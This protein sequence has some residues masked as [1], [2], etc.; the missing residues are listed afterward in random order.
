VLFPCLHGR[1]ERYHV[2]FNEH[3]Q[4][5]SRY[6]LCSFA[7]APTSRQKKQQL[8]IQINQCSN[9]NG[10]D[11]EREGPDISLVFIFILFLKNKK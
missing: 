1:A 6:R 5:V 4:C 9:L 7:Q 3:R 8:N 2:K 11:G 10:V